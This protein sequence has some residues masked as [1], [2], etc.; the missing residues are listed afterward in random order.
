MKEKVLNT[1]DG[2]QYTFSTYFIIN[3]SKLFSTDN[4]HFEYN[5]KNCYYVK[6]LGSN[7]HP[8]IYLDTKADN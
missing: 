1:F 4:F 7:I 2:K 5:L 3:S 8:K 6:K